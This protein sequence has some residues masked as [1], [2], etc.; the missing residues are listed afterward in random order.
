MNKRKV[1]NDPVHGFIKIPYDIIF[2]IIEH[3]YF[4]RLRRIKQLGLTDYVYPGALHTRFHH[5]LGAF[6]LMQ[7]AI[8]TLR[9]KD[10]EITLEEEQGALIAIL[11]H[12]IG[13][14]PFSHTLEYCL[15]DNVS[16]EYVSLL[17]MKKFN[18]IFSSKLYLAIEI[19]QNKYHKKFLFQLI[20]GQLD[21]DRLDYLTRDS[22]FTGVSEGVINYNRIIDMIAVKDNELVLE[23]KAIYSVEKFL[24]SRRI[25]YWQVYLHKTVICAEEMMI[26]ILLRAKELVADGINL[27]C[28]ES[29]SYFLKNKISKADFDKDSSNLEKYASM[30]DID[31]MAAIKQWMNCEDRVLSFL[32]KSLINRKLFTIKMQ[33]EP[34]DQAEIKTKLA[35]LMQEHKLSKLEAEKLLIQNEMTIY[36]YNPKQNKINILFKD[37]SLKDFA[38]AT[39]QWNISALGHPVTKHYVCFPK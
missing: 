35:S 10:V 19:L 16:H 29:L 30:D 26:Q 8:F 4:Q 31:I 11:L 28:S 2:D 34:L 13:H 17:Y 15:L 9:Q 33:N 32:C 12:D 23:A 27:A 18:E 5:A 21:V 37:G 38:D 20:S 39:D 22:F 7:K 14:A 24:I 1:L 36:L 25:M 3:P 6:H